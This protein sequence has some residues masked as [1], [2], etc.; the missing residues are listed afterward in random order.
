M[1]AQTT[2]NLHHCLNTY[3]IDLSPTWAQLLMNIV[4]LG[5]FE[6][7]S[8]TR[9][10]GSAGRRKKFEI[11]LELSAEVYTL[12]LR[13]VGTAQRWGDFHWYRLDQN[14]FWSHK[15]GSTPVT[16]S[17]NAGAFITDPRIANMGNYHFVSFMTS[18]YATVNIAGNS[19]CP[20]NNV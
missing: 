11:C 3:L 16:A 14:G 17:D 13:F 9:L 4:S 2:L 7:A 6:Q 18:D 5:T 1:V 8:V 10:Q 15:P 19:Y 20:Y 12:F